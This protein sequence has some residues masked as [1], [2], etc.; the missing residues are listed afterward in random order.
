MH[1]P[2]KPRNG[3]RRLADH[4]ERK[5]PGLP[6][7]DVRDKARPERGDPAP[8]IPTRPGRSPDD[9]STR[10]NPPPVT[11]VLLRFSGDSSRAR[12]ALERLGGTLDWEELTK[13]DLGPRSNAWRNGRRAELLALLG[14]PPEA[15][16]G[17]WLP[18]L[19]ALARRAERVAALDS[20]RGAVTLS[21]G[22]RYMA[23]ALP[24]A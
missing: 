12:P 24:A 7:G 18:P 23:S 20:G 8:L 15:W 11:A 14:E 3:A 10:R 22:R 6:H 19:P 2:A 4:P 9:H 16:I 1:T 5:Y 17:Y 13:A 21:S